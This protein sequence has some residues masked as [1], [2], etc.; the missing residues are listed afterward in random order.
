MAGTFIPEKE[1]PKANTAKKPMLVLPGDYMPITECAGELYPILATSGRYFVFEDQVVK[2]IEDGGK[3]RLSP[4]DM[5]AFCSELEGYFELYKRGVD[6]RGKKVLREGRCSQEAAVVLLKANPQQY[7]PSIKTLTNAAVF[8]EIDGSLEVLS[9][10]HHSI[11]GGIYVLK[12]RNIQK[13]DLQVAVAELL[14]LVNDFNFVTPADRS[15]AISALLSPALRMG[16]LLPGV[17]TPLNSAEA[18]ESQ[19]GKNFLMKIICALYGEKAYVIACDKDSASAIDEPLSEALCSG[20]P[21][22]LLDNVRGE[23]RSQKLESAIKGMGTVDAKRK[24]QPT[25][26]VTTDHV[27]WLLTSNGMSATRDLANRSAITRIKKQPIGHSYESYQEGDILA[28]LQA[29]T[30]RYLSCVFTVLDDWLQK[31]KPTTLEGRHDFREWTRALDWIVQNTFGLAPLMDG[32]REEQERV[33]NPSLG[34]LRQVAI[35]F[36]KEGKLGEAFKAAEILEMCEKHGIDVPGGGPRL[37]EKQVLMLAG[38][39]LGRLFRDGSTVMAGGFQVTRE[40]REEWNA[41]VKRNRPIHYYW[42]RDVK[43]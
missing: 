23:I 38:K 40:T 8:A 22:I 36:E 37:D 24:Y 17:D 9:K 42:F 32:H 26:Q 30:D 21:F 27:I 33:S 3:P 11:R 5:T 35:A 16:G 31:G 12:D 34:W 7:L 18:D 1:A 6:N 39:I 20:R 43:N 41:E 15:R 28:H 14:K 2:L 29:N 4:I 13:L 10:G 25:V 19:A